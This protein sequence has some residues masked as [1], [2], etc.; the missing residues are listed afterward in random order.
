MMQDQTT[1][2][3]FNVIPADPHWFFATGK[4]TEDGSTHITAFRVVGWA[5]VEERE[6]QK[7][8]VTYTSALVCDE[9]SDEIG[10]QLANDCIPK[11]G[12][13]LGCFW[14]LAKTTEEAVAEFTKTLDSES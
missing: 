2:K 12:W 5:F 1:Q 4:R 9:H 6:K 7:R 8:S 10:P 3:I 13:P 11:G 14:S